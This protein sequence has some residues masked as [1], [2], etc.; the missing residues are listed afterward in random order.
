ME[1]REIAIA[2]D[3]SPAEVQNEL[4]ALLAALKSKQPPELKTFAGMAYV[5][6]QAPSS[7]FTLSMER[8]A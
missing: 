2:E 4:A 1:T 7:R 6:L 3:K 5:L 8:R